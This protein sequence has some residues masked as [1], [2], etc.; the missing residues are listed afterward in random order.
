MSG[1]RRRLVGGGEEGRLAPLRAPGTRAR[2]PIAVSP[3]PFVLSFCPAFSNRTVVVCR[4]GRCVS[5]FSV[6]WACARRSP[7]ADS[8]RRLRSPP[9]THP[10]PPPPHPPLTPSSKFHCAPTFQISPPLSLQYPQPQQRPRASTGTS[11]TPASRI[12]SFSTCAR[13][14]TSS[15]LAAAIG[16]SEDMYDDGYTTVSNIDISKVCIDQM[17]E[18]YREKLGS[19]GSR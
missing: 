11:V 9:P 3:L 19:L 2:R 14:T 10:P 12:S 5:A 17:V 16:L 18:K 7:K 6:P 13:R 1:P 4:R 15:C 8:R